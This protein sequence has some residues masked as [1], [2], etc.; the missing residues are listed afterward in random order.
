TVNDVLVL[1]ADNMHRI[2]EADLKP[3]LR[4]G[5]NT[6]RVRLRSVLPVIAAK[7]AERHLPAWN[8]YSE[9]F[10]GKSWVRKMAC[11]FGWDWGPMVPTAGIWR[12][13]GVHA[14]DHGR[15]DAVRVQ[16]HHQPDGVTLAIT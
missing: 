15:L 1:S 4:L 14:A 10:R 13:I 11:A 7:D 6:V 16:Q 5:A 2:W 3:A 8:T 12:G 9:A